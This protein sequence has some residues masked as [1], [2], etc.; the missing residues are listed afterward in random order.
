MKGGTR[1]ELGLIDWPDE[2][3][4]RNDRHRW[5]T[6]I[7]TTTEALN[8]I[9]AALHSAAAK[10]D[11]VELDAVNGAYADHVV[12]MMAVSLRKL[13]RLLTSSWASVGVNNSLDVVVDLRAIAAAPRG[14]SRKLVTA[15]TTVPVLMYGHGEGETVLSCQQAKAYGFKR[16]LGTGAHAGRVRPG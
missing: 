3:A 13:N 16:T 2:S 7:D 10:A 15:P 12:Q 14:R 11:D 4:L 6:L 9:V 1:S 8:A 5:P